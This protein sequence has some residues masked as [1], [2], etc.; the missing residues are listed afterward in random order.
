[1]KYEA[2]ILE[3]V[4]LETNDIICTSTPTGLTPSYGDEGW[5]GTGQ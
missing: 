4:I 3:L 1:M 5:I 2:P